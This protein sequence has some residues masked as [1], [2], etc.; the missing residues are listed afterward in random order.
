MTLLEAYIVFVICVMLMT[1]YKVMS[2]PVV[3][4]HV[5]PMS[6]YR[7]GMIKATSCFF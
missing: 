6:H 1:V 7:E 3:K 5:N 4:T 2:H